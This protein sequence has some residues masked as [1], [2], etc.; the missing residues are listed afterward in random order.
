[1]LQ[2][3]IEEP[4]V[5]A[6]SSLR[7]VICSGEALPW[8]LQQRFTCLDAELHNLYGPTEAAIDVT[9]WAWRHSDLNIV[10]IGR[11]IANTQIYLLDDHLQ[12]V[13]IGVPGELHI[14]GVGSQR[15]SEPPLILRL[16][17]SLRI[18]GNAGRS[19]SSS[20]CTKLET[21]LLPAGWEHRVPGANR[22]PGKA[23][24]LPD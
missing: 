22:P 18:L 24:R 23:P 15:L 8:E 7:Q 14:G 19:P 21:C 16:R 12:P 2:V 1:M 3:F 20:G 4:G 5:K 11:P 6:C 9:F 13:P 17:S 10:P